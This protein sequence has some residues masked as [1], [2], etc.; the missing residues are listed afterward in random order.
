M[1]L[2]GTSITWST[3]KTCYV[4]IIFKSSCDGL[5]AIMHQNTMFGCGFIQGVIH[6]GEV[7]SGKAGKNIMGSRNRCQSF[8]LS[9]GEGEA[10]SLLKDGLLTSTEE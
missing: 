8:S 7:F 5:A 6:S 9:L 10:C 2:H 3:S 1:Y 4:L